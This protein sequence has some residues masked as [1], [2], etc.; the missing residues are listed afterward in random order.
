MF[1]SAAVAARKAGVPSALRQDVLSVP[2]RR[3]TARATR[4]HTQR[5]V[6]ARA[7]MSCSRRVD[8][9]LL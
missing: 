7:L 4:H 3:A 8:I 9:A 1:A 6:F 5:A 2:M